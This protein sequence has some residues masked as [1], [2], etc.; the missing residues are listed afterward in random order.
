MEFEFDIYVKYWFNPTENSPNYF[1]PCA[2]SQ[3]GAV[4]GAPWN[5]TGYQF[6]KIGEAYAGFYTIVE[7]PDTVTPSL[8][9]LPSIS[10][11]R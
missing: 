11:R 7:D 8:Q 10:P 2:G 1:H 5:Y 4:P 9:T 6:A 3:A